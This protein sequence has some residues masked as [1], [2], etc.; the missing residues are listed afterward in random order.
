MQRSSLLRYVILLLSV[1]LA[2][3]GARSTSGADDADAEIRLPPLK[4][5]TPQRI[6]ELPE[7]ERAA[8]QTYVARS[9]AFAIRE[10]KVLA[11]ELAAAGLDASRPAP[12][13]S[14]VFKLTSE[15]D[16]AFFS[17]PETA[18]LAD[19]FLSYQTPTGGW[20]KAVD[21]NQ[22]PRT[23][24]THWTSQSGRGWHYSGTLDN[25]ATTEQIGL[26]AQVYAVTGRDAYRQGALRGV[27]WLLD[28]QFPGGGWP[29]V[30][31]L[32]PGYHEAIT[33]NDD[34]MVHALEVL[35]EVSQGNA[36]YEFVDS[37]LQDEAKAA[38]EAGLACLFR[39][40]IVIDGAP[41]VWCAQ[42]DP[43]TLQPIAARIKEPA[44]LSGGES[45]AVVK[46]LMRQAPDTPQARRS[47]TAALAWFDAAKLTDLKRT[48]NAA[49]KTDYVDDPDSSEVY[50][51]RFYDLRTQEPVFAGADDGIIY[52]S[53]SEM[54]KHNKVAY[55]YFT[56]AP[57]ELLGKE[58]ER[59][60]KRIANR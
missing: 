34:A 14:Q 56:T 15:H 46:F 58:Y 10:R 49:G 43:L 30:Y 47:I 16:Q 8:W 2:C 50:W 53:Y 51:A 27:R 52:A 21:Y 18:K 3:L 31:P 37:S 33:L 55:D 29:Q 45:A 12:A 26:L 54:A 28:A 39:A 38:V 23:P 4:I 5:V 24:G 13:T 60:Q 42:H 36:P 6:A 32:Q 48:K 25:R 40:Q 59:W 44:S 20:S 11:A 17:K 9:Q 7:P 41:T 57:A 1:T 22:G 19:I 35:M